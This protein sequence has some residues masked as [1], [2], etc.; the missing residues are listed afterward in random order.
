MRILIADDEAPARVRLRRLVEELGECQVVGEAANG[1]EALVRCGEL[2]PDILLMD[3]RMP[4]MDGLEAARHLSTLPNAPAVIFTTAYADHALAAFEAHA[5]GYLL[6]PVRKERLEEALK[7]VRRLTRV[8]GD[9]LH[10]QEGSPPRTH[11]CAY[12][13]G[14]LQLIAVAQIRYFQADQK[15]VTVRFPEGRVLIEDPLKALEEELAA[16]FTRIHRNAL[17]ANAHLIGM[18][19][20]AAGYWQV[21]LHG[22]DE[23]LEVSRRHVAVLRKKLKELEV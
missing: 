14:S 3:I 23:R 4:G 21:H 11:I 2:T 16:V 1:R 15:Y 5:V 9:A 17:V 10:A 22:I 8:Q 20:T 6:K 13:R 7:A 18:E 12:M 19:K